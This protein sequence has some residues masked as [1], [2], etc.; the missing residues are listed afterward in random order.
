MHLSLV[1]GDKLGLLLLN[2][3][4]ARDAETS[5]PPPQSGDRIHIDDAQRYETAFQRKT[6]TSS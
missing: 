2:W 6:N 5:E 1:D 4:D 3:R